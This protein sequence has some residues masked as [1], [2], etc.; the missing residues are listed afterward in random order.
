[1]AQ[2]IETAMVKSR[3]QSVSGVSRP[4]EIIRTKSEE[5]L[6]TQVTSSYREGSSKAL[7]KDSSF[8]NG[9]GHFT[10]QGAQYAIT[11]TKS[12]PTPTPWSNVIANP[13]F[14]C[15]VTESVEVIRGFGNSRENKLTSWSNDPVLDTPSEI[16]YL[17]S[18]NSQ[19]PWSPV[20][21]I[22]GPR[23]RSVVHGQGYSKFKAR[24]DGCVCETTIA[25]M[26]HTQ[27]NL[28]G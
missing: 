5:K 27:S 12:N 13:E 17:H 14:G 25:V 15:L 10:E 22:G 20:V 19:Q 3:H 11:V 28:F 21:P 8:S 16:L 23:E 26:R 7:G 18:E 24:H 9:Y 6:E 4:I 1:M 2:Q